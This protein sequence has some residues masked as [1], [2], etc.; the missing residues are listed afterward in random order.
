MSERLEAL[1]REA[2]DC[3][4]KLHEALGPGLLESVYEACLADSLAKRGIF[5]ERQKPIPIRYNGVVLQEG[6]RADLLLE[7]QLLIE[8]KSTEASSP[9]HGKQVLTYLRLMNLPLGLLMNFG[10][11]TFRQGIRRIANNYQ[12]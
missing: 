8:L 2:V 4:F 12:D 1:A 5:V 9:I 7:E 11:E 6:F 10:F 3:G